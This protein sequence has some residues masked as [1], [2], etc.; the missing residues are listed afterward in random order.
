MNCGG[1]KG[2]GAHSPRC[3]TQP[4]WQYKVMADQAESLG[5]RIGANDPGLANMAYHIA[6]AMKKKWREAS[7]P[8]PPIN[9]KLVAT[10]DD[11]PLEPFNDCPHP[12]YEHERGKPGW[13][14]SWCGAPE[15]NTGEK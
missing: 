11:E 13:W 7:L 1:C 2:L 6:G 14:C 12:E 8:L 4:G 9:K 3:P 10:V 5:D 15:N